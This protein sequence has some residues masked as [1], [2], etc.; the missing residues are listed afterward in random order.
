MYPNN[1]IEVTHALN[2]TKYLIDVDLIIGAGIDTKTN[3]TFLL[4]FAGPVMP[5]LETPEFIMKHKTKTTI[6]EKVNV[7]KNI[8]KRPNRKR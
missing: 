5:I 7:R 6:K 2:H 4:S 1:I 3:S 8:Q